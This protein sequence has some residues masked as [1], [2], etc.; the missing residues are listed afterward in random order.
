[1]AATE[2]TTPESTPQRR[3]RPTVLDNVLQAQAREDALKAEMDAAYQRF[4]EDCHYPV[5]KSGNVMNASHFVFLVGYHMVRCGWRP[6]AE[7]VIKK[8][9]VDAPGVVEDAIEWVAID[10]PDDPLD[11]VENMTFAEIAELP[12]WL[13][14]KAIKRLGGGRDVDDDLPEMQEPAWQV[15]PNIAITT[16]AD[17]DDF[18]PK[19]E[20]AQ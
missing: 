19:T 6:T 16:A 15:T 5:D 2:N 17:P 12:E 8:R 10:A 7:P 3:R 9:R 18:I 1:M 4:V 20:E 13:R 11:G 14:R